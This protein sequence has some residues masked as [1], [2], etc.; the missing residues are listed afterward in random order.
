[1]F[2]AARKKSNLDDVFN[3]DSS[4]KAPFVTMPRTAAI[5]P[6]QPFPEEINPEWVAENCVE[7]PKLP[8]MIPAPDMPQ[9]PSHVSVAQSEITPLILIRKK[10]EE[11]RELSM[12]EN[13]RLSKKDRYFWV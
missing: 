6:Q 4:E 9:A 5:T 2:E 7:L 10:V 12:W 1:V 8:D 13:V 3:R 11:Y